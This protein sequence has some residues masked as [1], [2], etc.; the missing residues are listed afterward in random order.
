MQNSFFVRLDPPS[1]RWRGDA[2]AGACL[3]AVDR[4]FVPA[5][6][7]HTRAEVGVASQ[8]A[9]PPPAQSRTSPRSV[10][11]GHV[12]RQDH[13]S[14]RRDVGVVGRFNDEQ[15]AALTWPRQDNHVSVIELTY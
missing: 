8:A 4:F 5:S 1:L 14:L 10:G 9:K 3:E 12:A 11:C 6:G 15:I 2:Q 13:L 7:S